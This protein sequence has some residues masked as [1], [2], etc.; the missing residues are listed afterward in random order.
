MDVPAYQRFT[1][2]SARL[3]PTFAEESEELTGI[4]LQLEQNGG[5]HPVMTE[6][7]L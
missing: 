6:D 5:L 7:A 3:W 1:R 2:T 4:D